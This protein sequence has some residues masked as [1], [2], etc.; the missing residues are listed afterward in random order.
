MQQL[1]RENKL[2]IM[3][4]LIKK[5]KKQDFSPN[6]VRGAYSNSVYKILKM[7]FVI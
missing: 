5:K 2:L 7:T 1:M 6:W 4:N 3:L